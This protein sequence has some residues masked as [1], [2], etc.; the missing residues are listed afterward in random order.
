MGVD[1]EF[2]RMSG[3]MRCWSQ[4]KQ[5]V[6]TKAP[7]WK[8]CNLNVQRCGLVRGKL[9]RANPDRSSQLRRYAGLASIVP[10]VLLFLD[11]TFL[12][13]HSPAYIDS[14]RFPL[15]LVTGKPPGTPTLTLSPRSF[16][17]CGGRPLAA[18]LKGTSRFSAAGILAEFS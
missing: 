5:T 16:Q 8:P 14:Y 17:N 12:Q 10:A 4:R 3:C 6:T 1:S 9:A 18:N 7:S 2:A 11:S 13:M 15:S